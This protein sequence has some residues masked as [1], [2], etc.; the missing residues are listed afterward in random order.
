MGQYLVDNGWRYRRGTPIGS[1]IA[2]SAINEVMSLRCA[3]K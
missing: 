3:K 1:S 2:E